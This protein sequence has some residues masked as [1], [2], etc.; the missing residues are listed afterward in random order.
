MFRTVIVAAKNV[1][2][3]DVIKVAGTKF[4]IEAIATFPD[5]QIGLSFKSSSSMVRYN[6]YF[7]SKNDALKIHQK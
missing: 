4:E 7:V 3:G 2:I 6:T 1:R 5:D